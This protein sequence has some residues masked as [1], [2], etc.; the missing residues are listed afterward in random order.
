MPVE[1]VAGVARGVGEGG[2][3]EAIAEDEAGGVA[4]AV[5][6]QRH[7]VDEPAEPLPARQQVL[8]R[9]IAVHQGNGF[10]VEGAA[11]QVRA[12]LALDARAV[13]RQVGSAQAL[14]PLAP[15]DLL[16]ASDRFERPPALPN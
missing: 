4:R 5:V 7:R 8:G 9:D 1:A 11:F 15:R 13:E 3:Q 16:L 12:Q 14:E 10:P 6:Q 2:Q